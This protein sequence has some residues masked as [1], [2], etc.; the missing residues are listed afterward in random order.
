MVLYT[1]LSVK[2]DHGKLNEILNSIKGISDANLFTVSVDEIT[3]VVS[4][5]KR[6]DLIADKTNAIAFAGVI[7]ILAQQFTLLPVR[8][9]SIMES[10]DAIVK[11]LEKNYQEIYRNLEKVENKFEFGLKI[12]CDSE[13]LKT[14]LISKSVVED[15]TSINQTSEIKKSVF[16]DY[17]NKKLAAHRLEELLITHVDSVIAEI[18]GHLA[19]LNTISKFKKMLTETTIVDAVFLLEKERKYPLINVIEE[20]KKQYPGLNFILTGPWPPYNFVD[21]TIK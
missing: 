5:H 6:T 11:M 2:S 16:R 20:L 14:S 9:G 8:F 13:K 19:K 15:S 1:I 10:T 18:K 17:V 4:D 12:F 3:V 7:E 21:F